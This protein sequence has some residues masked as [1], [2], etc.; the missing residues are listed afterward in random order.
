MWVFCQNH[1]IPWL[2]PHVVE[3]CQPWLKRDDSDYRKHTRCCLITP[4][5]SC[6]FSR[7]CFSRS[8]VSSS[9]S[10]RCWPSTPSTWVRSEV[11]C[12]SS[13]R[14]SCSMRRWAC[15]ISEFSSS[16]VNRPSFNRTR[17][18]KKTHTHTH[19]MLRYQQKMPLFLNL[20]FENTVIYLFYLFSHRT[21][22][23][24]GKFKRQR[25]RQNASSVKKYAT[26][27]NTINP[28]D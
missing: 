17:V 3:T 28:I 21:H 24:A 4:S 23:N 18:H 19:T 15:A 9:C 6:I 5:S 20:C 8:S 1:F 26:L 2:K 11:R 22:C 27:Y 7:S 16:A 14:S 12:F 10:C 25:R 13:R